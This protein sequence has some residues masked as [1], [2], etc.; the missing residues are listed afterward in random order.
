MNDLVQPTGLRC[1]IELERSGPRKGPAFSYP[2]FAPL[3]RF[4]K[5]YMTEVT[6]LQCLALFLQLRPLFPVVQN[7]GQSIQSEPRNLESRIQY[8]NYSLNHRALFAHQWYSFHKD[9]SRPM[10]LGGLFCDPARRRS[11]QIP[12]DSISSG[13]R[14]FFAI[15]RLFS[16]GRK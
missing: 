8:D 13:L 14:T 11:S 1:E 4:E 9:L 16:F 12:I 10:A 5:H 7:E 15:S 3:T 2:S 6:F